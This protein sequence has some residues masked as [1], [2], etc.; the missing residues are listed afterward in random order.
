LTGAVATRQIINGL[1]AHNKLNDWSMAL[2]TNSVESIRCHSKSV[3]ISDAYVVGQSVCTSESSIEFFGVTGLTLRPLDRCPL[4][5]SPVSEDVPASPL[6][7][8]PNEVSLRMEFHVEAVLDMVTQLEEQH[9]NGNESPNSDCWDRQDADVRTRV[10]D[11]SRSNLESQL[12][13]FFLAEVEYDLT[14]PLVTNN[15]Y[16][17]LRRNGSPGIRSWPCPTARLESLPSNLYA[18]FIIDDG[19]GVG[20]SNTT[21]ENRDNNGFGQPFILTPKSPNEGP[22]SVLC[23][24]LLQPTQSL[25][26]E[27]I[28]ITVNQDLAQMDN[29]HLGDESNRS[30]CLVSTPQAGQ[31]GSESAQMKKDL[32]SNNSAG[33]VLTVSYTHGEEDATNWFNQPGVLQTQLFGAAADHW[34]SKG[35][36][37]LTM[38]VHR[39]L[40]HRWV[41]CSTGSLDN[42]AVIPEIPD[43]IH[44][45]VARMQ[46]SAHAQEEP[47][48]SQIESDSLPHLMDYHGRVIRLQQNAWEELTRRAHLLIP[49]LFPSSALSLPDVT[50]PC[51]FRE[52]SDIVQLVGAAQLI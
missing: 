12:I 8:V 16:H 41:I 49:A 31:G 3:G 27:V 9:V 40:Q 20:V 29:F 18:E 30:T 14:E 15:P 10:T 7:L 32:D 46:H 21:P 33:S 22:V 24:S 44:T 36:A 25:S 17:F 23:A 6:M 28:R 35:D 47:L 48:L 1:I 34:W 51:A 50:E 11:L 37:L 5:Y 43:P 38:A 2:P 4:L 19:S 45:H 42:E 26:S 13:E 52:L 39:Y